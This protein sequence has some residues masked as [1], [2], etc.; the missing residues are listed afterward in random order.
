MA[1]RAPS[2]LRRDAW[3]FDIERAVAMDDPVA[4]LAGGWDALPLAMATTT[5]TN[6]DDDDAAGYAL[7]I[8]RS[9]HSCTLVDGHLHV[10]GGL[11]TDGVHGLPPHRPLS[12]WLSLRA[13]AEGLACGCALRAQSATTRSTS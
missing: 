7:A 8:N 3:A 10:F 13:S 12:C 11:S 5:P 1:V 2:A 6:D 9:D 4:P